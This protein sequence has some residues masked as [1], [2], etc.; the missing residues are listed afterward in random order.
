MKVDI[1]LLHAVV[2]VAQAGGFREAAR[3]TL[4]AIVSRPPALLSRPAFDPGT[5]SRLY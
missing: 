1:A 4:V 5:A 2:A 3:V